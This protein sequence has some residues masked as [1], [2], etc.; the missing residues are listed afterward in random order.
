M[1]FCTHVFGNGFGQPLK[2]ARV[3][4]ARPLYVA[5]REELIMPSM[6]S[7]TESQ[8][9]DV[10]DAFIEKMETLDLHVLVQLLWKGDDDAWRYV[11]ARAVVPLLGRASL[12]CMVRDR[13]R[14][15]LDVCGAVFD[16]LIAQKKLSNYHFECPVVYWIRFYVAKDILGYCKKND[17]PL[18]D[19]GLENVLTTEKTPL[20]ELG[21]NEEL[22]WC[23]KRLRQEKRLMSDVLYLRAI[24]G[25]SSVEVM[26]LL[27]ISSIDNVNQLYKRARDRMSELL[28]ESRTIR[29]H[30]VKGEV[31]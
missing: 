22:N 14:S 15:D 27:N 5:F 16:Y 24:E 3:K 7:M 29:M 31:V 9:R 17:N 6:S 20:E 1:S 19:D 30:G 18:S 12:G 8:W 10:D 25:R 11:Y 13:K 23:Y 26:N 28:R 21:F 2:R 4:E